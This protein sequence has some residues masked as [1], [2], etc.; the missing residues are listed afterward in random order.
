MDIEVES[1]GEVRA[2]VGGQEIKRLSDQEIRS[3]GQRQRIGS[4]D[5]EMTRS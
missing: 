4:G 2:R 1:K 3:G 5:E